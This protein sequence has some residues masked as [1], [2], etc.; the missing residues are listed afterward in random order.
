MDDLDLVNELGGLGAVETAGPQQILEA[1]ER[2]IPG[3]HFVGRHG[4]N[5]TM[6]EQYTSATTGLRP[7]GT[8]FRGRYGPASSRF[9]SAEL[10]LRAIVDADF[11]YREQGFPSDQNGRSGP[12][13]VF[14]SQGN[15]YGEGYWSRGVGP[16]TSSVARGYYVNDQLVTIF[17]DL[18]PKPK[19]P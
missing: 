6:A 8:Q 14:N 1:L 17:P 16:T 11:E 3:A 9:Y 15:D 4:A 2:L 7:D 19:V 18:G 13:S 10:Q 12:I 5:T